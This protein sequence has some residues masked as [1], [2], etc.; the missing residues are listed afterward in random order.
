MAR[1]I[2]VNSE[3][4]SIDVTVQARSNIEVTLSRAVISAG[5]VTN[6]NA[7]N[8]ISINTSTG[9]VTISTT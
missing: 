8:N 5:V 7:G 1:Q 9:N 4:K 2:T 6:I 3:N